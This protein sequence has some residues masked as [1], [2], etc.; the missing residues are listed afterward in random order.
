MGVSYLLR[1]ILYAYDVS[2]NP[3]GFVGYFLDIL[4]VFMYYNLLVSPSILRGIGNPLPYLYV[5]RWILVYIPPGCPLSLGG[6]FFLNCG[7]PSMVLKAILVLYYV[8]GDT[9]PGGVPYTPGY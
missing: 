6:G 8:C 3:K 5:F 7:E 1:P 9:F 4:W 2:D